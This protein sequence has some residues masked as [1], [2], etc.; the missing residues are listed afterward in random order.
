MEEKSNNE[1]FFMIKPDYDVLLEDWEDCCIVQ[2]DDDIELELDSNTIL[3]INIPGINA[4][5]NLYID[6]TDFFT[7]STNPAFDWDAWHKQGI[8]FARQIRLQL[9]DEIDLWYGYP[10]EDVGSRNK[11]PILIYKEVTE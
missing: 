4:W 10:Y 8:I 5:Y 1:K 9:P 6:A 3:K 2:F 7:C 11:K